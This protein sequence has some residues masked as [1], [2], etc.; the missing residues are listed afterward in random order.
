M[1][2]VTVRFITVR[3]RKPTLHW[4]LGMSCLG[5][6][7]AILRD[8]GV[9]IKYVRTEGERGRLKFEGSSLQGGSWVKKA[10]KSAYI[11]NGRPLSA[12]THN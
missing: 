7:V 8:E 6:G 1:L 12:Y 11:L 2:A 3:R 10:G 5:V 9:S 4:G